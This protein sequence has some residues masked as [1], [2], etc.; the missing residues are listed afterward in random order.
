MLTV[1]CR[2]RG[3]LGRGTQAQDAQNISVQEETKPALEREHFKPTSLA[4]FCFLTFEKDLLELL[5]FSA[6]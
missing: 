1:T 6:G 3:M 4:N 5:A 2:K